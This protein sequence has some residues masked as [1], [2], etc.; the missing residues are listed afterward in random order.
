MPYNQ[1][2]DWTAEEVKYS[3]EKSTKNTSDNS[4]NSNSNT[5]QNDLFIEVDKFL[6]EYFVKKAPKVPEN[7]KES[8]V[9]YMPVINMATIVFTIFGRL[10]IPLLAFILRSV[11]WTPWL[12]YIFGT[13][14]IDGTSL[15]ITV[16]TVSFQIQAQPGLQSKTLL[17][18]K[19]MVFAQI[20]SGIG[21]ILTLNLT[22]L[23]FNT[24]WLYFI[25]QVKKY[26]KV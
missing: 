26:Y 23:L 4:K 18:W 14:S 22:A 20:C 9:I 5:F 2:Q 24:L 13:G 15:L 17:A 16:A 3:K 12:Y 8:L 11:F 21:Y 7:V 25:Y 10:L 19:F 1:S 6:D